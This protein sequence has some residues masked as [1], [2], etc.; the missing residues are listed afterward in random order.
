[1]SNFNNSFENIY[2][3]TLWN[4]PLNDSDI[5]YCDKEAELIRTTL[6]A[7][8]TTAMC[9]KGDYGSG[10]T[11][12]A[13]YYAEK[14]SVLY[15]A[16][17][18][19]YFNFLEFYEF[20][21]THSETAFP[22]DKNLIIADEINQ[23]MYDS[24]QTIDKFISRLIN[25]KKANVN[26]HI[27][28]IGHTIHPKLLKLCHTVEMSPVNYSKIY[29]TV[30]KKLPD[31]LLYNDKLNSLVSEILSASEGNPRK[32]ITIIS[33]L[34]NS[35]S[36][37]PE[38]IISL[39]GIVDI[40]GNPLKSDNSAFKDI[41]ADLVCANDK[42]FKY[43][44]EHPEAM[45]QMTGTEFEYFIASI[46]DRLGY[47]TTITPPTNDGG[48]DIYAAKKDNLGSF[49]FL[50]QCKNKKA[51]NPV[52]INIIRELYGVLNQKNATFASVFTTSYFSKPAIEF[53]EQFSHQLS[54]HDYNY[55]KSLLKGLS[56][57]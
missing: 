23:F 26:T 43:F 24:S 35:G 16:G 57:Q 12:L 7:P 3:V 56:E 9:I 38:Q 42:V 32:L 27:I 37:F 29:D 47:K 17:V 10:K 15:P 8:D 53:Q 52:G 18:K 54:L 39:P 40:Q 5:I 21:E 19:Y 2:P 13:K 36:I 20:I 25:F 51:H 55:I 41:K 46:L 48:V 1:M 30:T 45:Y 14:Y 44:S 28:L 31:T 49:L 50:V 34:D 6:S 22:N 4:S 33:N 11:Y